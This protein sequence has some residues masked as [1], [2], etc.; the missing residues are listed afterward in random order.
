MFKNKYVTQGSSDYRKNMAVA[1]EPLPDKFGV[2]T[3]K[4]VNLEHKEDGDFAKHMYVQMV[5]IMVLHRVNEAFRRC[6][7]M[8]FM[9]ICTMPKLDEYYTR[10]DPR[11]MWDDSAIN[12][13]LS[14][15]SLTRRQVLAWQYCVNK[16]FSEGDCIA[17]TWLKVFMYNSSTDSLRS[18][19]KKEIFEDPSRLSRWCD[20]CLPNFV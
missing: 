7:E 13:W 8:D 9:D 20:L 6:K 12:L 2:S 17:S 5:I 11:D 14:W 16:Y 15:D 19:V 10:G 1:T 18:A 4:I 3:H